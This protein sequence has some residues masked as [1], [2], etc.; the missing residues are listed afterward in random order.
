[1]STRQIEGADIKGDLTDFW[2]IMY[3]V[4]RPVLRIYWVLGLHLGAKNHVQIHRIRADPAKFFSVQC[5]MWNTV[6]YPK[7]NG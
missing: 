4:I 1:M 6:G 7:M 3:K 5:L 2:Y